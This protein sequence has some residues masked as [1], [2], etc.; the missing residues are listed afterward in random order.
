MDDFSIWTVL[1]EYNKST[2]VKRVS[3]L[4]TNQQLME[5]EDLTEEGIHKDP[6][7][8]EIFEGSITEEKKYGKTPHGGAYSVVKYLNGASMPVAKSD[9]KKMFCI[10]FDKDG[11][12]IHTQLMYIVKDEKAEVIQ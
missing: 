6:Q 11:K 7:E 2:K 3:D 8:D 1:E 9:A 12:V 4:P 5:A 10:E